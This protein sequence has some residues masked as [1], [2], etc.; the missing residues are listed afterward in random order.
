[1]G[2]PGANAQ[3]DCLECPPPTFGP[4]GLNNAFLKL[5]EKGFPGNTEQ[6]MLKWRGRNAFNKLAEK[7]FPGNTENVFFKFAPGE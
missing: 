2:A 7:G 5:A 4:P 6:A 3:E 1:M